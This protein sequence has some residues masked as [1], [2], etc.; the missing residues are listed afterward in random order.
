MG[1]YFNDWKWGVRFTPPLGLLL[2]LAIIFF[3]D[4]PKRV[5]DE[6]NNLMK[7][8][9]KLSNVT[10]FSV[11]NTIIS[12][13]NSYLNDL[14]YLMLKL[15]FLLK[16]EINKLLFLENLMFGLFLDMFACFLL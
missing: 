1:T 8:T 9:S 2:I 10:T 7:N 5:S 12:I 3:L 6:N 13:K 4:E 14:K 16:N 11:K 15:V